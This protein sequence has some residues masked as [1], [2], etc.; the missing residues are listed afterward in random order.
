MKKAASLIL[1]IVL[2]LSCAGAFAEV[3]SL[4]DQLFGYAKDAVSYLASGAYEKLVTSLPFSD[5]S[6]SADEW[7]SFAQGNF[8]TLSGASP[9]QTYAVAYWTGSCWKIAVPVFEPSSDSVEALIL[10]SS[11]GTSFSGYGY[12][13]WGSVSSEYQSADYVQWNQEYVS[14]TS[15]TIEN[16]Y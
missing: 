4:D 1:I 14:S 5:V 16:D 3:P 9:Q 12:S 13:N 7:Q 6:P 11:D 15:V 2:I 8:S 10:V